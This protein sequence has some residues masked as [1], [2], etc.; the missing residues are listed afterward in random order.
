MLA[1]STP[2]PAP[3]PFPHQPRLFALL[4][5]ML[6]SAVIL[7]QVLPMQGLAQTSSGKKE[8]ECRACA[9]PLFLEKIHENLLRISSQNI[10]MQKALA[11]SNKHLKALLRFLGN[12]LEQHPTEPAHLLPKGENILPP[13]PTPLEEITHSFSTYASSVSLPFSQSKETKLVIQLKKI[14]EVSAADSRLIQDPNRRTIP[15]IKSTSL[16]TLPT[17][18]AVATQI[19]R[20]AMEP[21][22]NSEYALLR[23]RLLAFIKNH[24]NSK[25][26]Y[27]AC[28]WIAQT[29]FKDGDF[30]S[31][32]KYYKCAIKKNNPKRDI[33]LLRIADIYIEAQDYAASSYVL[34][35]LKN[36]SKNSAVQ[37]I[38]LQRLQMLE[39][40]QR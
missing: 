13:P 25:H 17:E 35:K 40:K 37:K 18:D 12:H 8:N 3:T 2:P 9:S 21:L 29:H 14:R 22:Q 36:E 30:T 6:M 31:A 10:T 38:V 34:Q 27:P 15:K 5:F 11:H 20:E 28:Y 19:F 32:M 7:I 39:Q 26:V 24:K 33:S 16:E 23:K 4:F 1:L